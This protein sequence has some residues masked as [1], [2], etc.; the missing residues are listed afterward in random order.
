MNK[1]VEGLVTF[2]AVLIFAIFASALLSL[3]VMLLWD[4][5]VPSMFGLPEITWVKAWGLMVLC[6]LLF[7][8]SEA[9]IK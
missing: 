7:T 5:I 9:K 2:V 1:L 6:K 3:P 4:W 8:S